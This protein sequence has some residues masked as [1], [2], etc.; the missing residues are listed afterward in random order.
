MVIGKKDPYRAPIKD[1]NWGSNQSKAAQARLYQLL[2][3]YGGDATFTARANSAAIEYLHYLH[4]VNPLGLVYLTNMKRAGAENSANTLYH[5]WFA[6]GSPRW[7]RVTDTT[8]GPPPGYLVGG[9]NPTFALDGCCTA[10]VGTA[11]YQCYGACCFFTVQ[12]KLRAASRTAGNEIVSTVQRG[13]AR[14]F[15]AGHRTKYI[16]SGRVHSCFG[17]LRALM[18]TCKSCRPAFELAPCRRPLLSG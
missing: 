1:Y 17:C 6:H 8:P 9:P 5:R 12:P 4:G 13:L 16:L 10:L 2:A 11:A 15:L 3:L 14:K 18:K 7:D